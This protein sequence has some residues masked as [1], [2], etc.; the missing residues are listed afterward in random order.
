MTCREF[1]ELVTDYLEG[2]L[3]P[4]DRERFDFHLG[5]C[6]GCVTYLEQIRETIAFTGTLREDD[7][8][9][10][11]RDELLAAFRDWKSGRT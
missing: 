4:E 6:P 5:V 10:P 11:A 1:V 7:I 9:A 2:R 8:A 3:A